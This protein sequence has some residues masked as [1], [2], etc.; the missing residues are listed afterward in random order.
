MNSYFINELKRKVISHEFIISIVLFIIV[1]CINAYF[2]IYSVHKIGVGGLTLF[3]HSTI[4]GYSLFSYIAPIIAALPVCSKFI[5]S[6]A[7]GY[8]YQEFIRVT[9]R[10]YFFAQITTSMITGAFVFLVAGILY[11]LICLLIDPAYS[12]RILPMRYIS[13]YSM[14]YAKSLLGYCAIIIANSMAFGISYAL[15]ALGISCNFRN[16]VIVLI[17]ITVFYVGSVFLNGINIMGMPI[18]PCGAFVML[19]SSLATIKDHIFVSI[20]GIILFKIGF[21]RNYTI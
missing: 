21:N 1:G 18:F 15:L 11:L 14:I 17:V 16:K 19:V 9:K 7:H 8:V 3:A 5:D 6:I 2:N 4:L 10:Q 13:A 12:I 20:L